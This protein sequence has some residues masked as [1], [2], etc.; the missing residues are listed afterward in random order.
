MTKHEFPTDVNARGSDEGIRGVCKDVKGTLRAAPL[1]SGAGRRAALSDLLGS[2][3]SKLPIFLLV[4]GGHNARRRS[5]GLR[6]GFLHNLNLEAAHLLKLL[7]LFSRGFSGFSSE[8]DA[9]R[10]VAGMNIECH[11][12]P[13][14]S[15]AYTRIIY[16]AIVSGCDV[17]PQTTGL[18]PVLDP[19]QA[20]YVS[21]PQA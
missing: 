9:A 8:R 5:G 18:N 7:G 21:L 15:S 6:L 14:I 11:L 17:Q 13:Q 12:R 2:R 1:M 3:F 19:R 4:S 20:F 16:P 10:S